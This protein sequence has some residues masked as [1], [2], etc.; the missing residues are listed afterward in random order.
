[1][2]V[3]MKRGG[4][5]R[6]AHSSKSEFSYD[7]TRSILALSLQKRKDG[8]CSRIVNFKCY[9]TF[10]INE[11]LLNSNFSMGASS[12]SAMQHLNSIMFVTYWYMGWSSCAKITLSRKEIDFATDPRGEVPLLAKPQ[13]SPPSLARLSHATAADFS[14]F[15]VK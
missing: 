15:L 11:T 9:V 14:K 4:G 2:G 3:G 1:M 6:G 10:I 7:D 12:F 5:K 13:L 8:E